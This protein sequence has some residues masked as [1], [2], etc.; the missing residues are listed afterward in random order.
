MSFHDCSFA[1]S[2]VDRALSLCIGKAKPAASMRAILTAQKSAA[3]QNAIFE[4]CWPVG[5]SQWDT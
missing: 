3:P 4:D 2:L 5:A 1:P